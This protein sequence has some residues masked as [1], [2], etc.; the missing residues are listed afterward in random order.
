MSIGEEKSKERINKMT[1]Y[2]LWIKSK[3]EERIYQGGFFNLN[4]CIDYLNFALKNPRPL[5]SKPEQKEKF[6]KEDFEIRKIIISEFEKSNFIKFRKTTKPLES[7]EYGHLARM[8]KDEIK[9]LLIPL[10]K[11][12]YVLYA[13]EKRIRRLILDL[14]K[15][16]YDPYEC[17]ESSII[18][19][20]KKDKLFCYHR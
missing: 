8:K 9:N 3:T 10:H 20:F 13:F 5:F 14:K 4:N 15:C 2:E 16:G 11:Q 7:G 18:Y 12:K 1:I 19:R 6:K 17:Y